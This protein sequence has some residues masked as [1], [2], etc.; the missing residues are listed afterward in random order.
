MAEFGGAE[1]NLL[2]YVFPYTRGPLVK[3]HFYHFIGWW[4]WGG[5]EEW[6]FCVA[7]G[8]W[9]ILQTYFYSD[10]PLNDGRLQY[11]KYSLG[12]EHDEK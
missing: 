8:A 5:V 7:C 4:C 2:G 12:W 1:G 6:V 10:S 9:G 3:I 11:R